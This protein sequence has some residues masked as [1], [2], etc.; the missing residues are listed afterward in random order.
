MLIDLDRWFTDD[1]D[2]MPEG[3]LFPYDVFLSHRRFD[4]PTASL[5][6]LRHAGLTIIWD[7]DL[8]LRDRRVMQ[9]VSRAMCGSR[10][11]ALFVS[12][13]YA[14]SPWCRAEYLNGLWVEQKY[15]VQRVI[16]LCESAASATRIPTE[17]RESRC[18]ILNPEG[19]AQLALFAREGN[20]PDDEGMLSLAFA[21]VPRYRLS[22]STDELTRDEH[23]NLLE[24]RLEFWAEEGSAAITLST[25]E[26]QSAH[27]ALLLRD[28]ITEPEKIFREGA[29]I[30]IPPGVK[31]VL[32]DGIGASELHRLVR[33]AKC[34]ANAYANANLLDT[35]LP[36]EKWAFDFLLKPLL[37]AVA[38]PETGT[39]AA[40]TFRE[41]CAL[42][43]SLEVLLETS[44]YL[45]ILN[46]VESGELTPDAAVSR[47]RSR[48]YHASKGGVTNDS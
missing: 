22:Q 11:V 6:A 18:F 47:S 12:D 20:T 45:E 26:H 32:R 3:Q 39:A 4:L 13:K 16:V 2:V 15:S 48:L 21:R 24:Q 46:L 25:K 17:L 14:D 35:L 29:A 44:V 41:L 23:L 34:I 42:F 30:I 38:Q 19:V 8:D 7:N 40:T 10:Y 33:M 27:L 1:S 31:V 37:L 5:E 9:G 43:R 36:F 28:P